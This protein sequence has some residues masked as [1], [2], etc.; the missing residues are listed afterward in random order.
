[1][2][3]KNCIAHFMV[4][5]ELGIPLEDFDHLL[6]FKHLPLLDQEELESIRRLDLENSQL[7]SIPKEIGGLKGLKRLYLH[8]NQPQSIPKE[9]GELKSLERLYL[10]N[11]QLQ[12]IP[13]EIGELKNLEWLDLGNNQ[14]PKQHQK[15]IKSWLPKCDICF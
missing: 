13:K 8:N 6:I 1:M 9:I 3:H 2:N 4:R 5:R 15:E 14:L 7:Q 11:N 12:S 10:R